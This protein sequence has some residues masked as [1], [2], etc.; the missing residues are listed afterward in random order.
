MSFSNYCFTSAS[1]PG[2]AGHSL[3][4]DDAVL[5]KI[6]VWGQGRPM[7]NTN[8]EYTAGRNMARNFAMFLL[9][10]LLL[11]GPST[12]LACDFCLIHQ[13]I[14]PLDTQN[15]KGLRINQRYTLLPR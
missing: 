15:G 10:D 14:S 6:M 1:R 8:F 4:H 3:T 13:G 5:D 7:Q 2:D 11:T 9:T 12:T